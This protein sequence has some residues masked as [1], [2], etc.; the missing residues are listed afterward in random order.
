MIDGL[1]S[2][3]DNYVIKENKDYAIDGNSNVNVIGTSCNI[4]DFSKDK[5]ISIY[6]DE[7]STVNYYVVNSKNS[8]RIFNVCG[9]L[10]ILSISLIK[11]DEELKVNLNSKNAVLNVKNLVV[12]NGITS[13]F[14]QNATHNETN[15]FSN[16][17]NVGISFNGGN[18]TFDTT[19]K[20]EKGMN[21]TK[22]SQ[23]SRGIVMDNKSTVT[24]KPILL[25]DEFDCFANHGAA[26][27]KM[28]DEDLFYLMSRGLTKDE[29]FLLI[30]GGMVKP[31]V[32]S[33]PNEVLKA[34]V[35]DS[36]NKLILS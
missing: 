21:K 19:G 31:F 33:I 11:N 22:C 26:I 7:N 18:I 10:N 14:T 4:Y 20:I 24:A 29:A 17:E 32:D 28:S 36:I 5:N 25:I 23:L 3:K 16:V 30:L 6:V 15:T 13:T 35:E 27:G 8:N 12:A 2:V 34:E 1:I 9:T